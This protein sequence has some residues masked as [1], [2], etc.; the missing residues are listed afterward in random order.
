MEPAHSFSMEPDGLDF[1]Q[2]PV[3]SLDQIR[4]IRASNDYVERPVALEPTSQSGF[5]HA[6]EERYPHGFSHHPPPTLQQALPRSQSQT[7]HAHLVHL[8]RSSTVSSSM[9]RTS[10]AS[11]QRLLVGPTSSHSGQSSVVRGQPKSDLKPEVSLA[12]G[13]ADIE[14]ELGLHLFIC[15][16]CGRCKCGEC[17]TPRRLPSCWACGQRCLCSAES[18]I[19]YG[20][21]LCCVK[22]LFYHCSAQDDV[23]NCADRPCSCT[24]Q[25]ACARWGAM[26]LMAL[27]LPCLCCYP[28]ARLCLTLCQHV[29]DRATRP[30]CRC[31]NTNTVCRKISASNATPGHP[32]LSSKTQEK[33]L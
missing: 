29:H 5:F 18:A 10:T 17:C 20:T 6:H 8:S 9:S 26:G 11:D 25:H 22:G 30:G 3:L 13:L 1:Q 19:E 15:E 33:P 2:V 23:D 31:S 32:P 24:Q 16:R 12:K 21:C 14:A 4:A 28:L 7:Q 27:C